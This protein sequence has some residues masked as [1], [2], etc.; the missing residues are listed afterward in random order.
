MG[1]L[2]SQESMPKVSQEA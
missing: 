1:R 2:Y